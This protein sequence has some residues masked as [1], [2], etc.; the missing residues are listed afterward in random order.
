VPAIA[1][2]SAGGAGSLAQADPKE[3]VATGCFAAVPLKGQA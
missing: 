1:D 2:Q 3:S